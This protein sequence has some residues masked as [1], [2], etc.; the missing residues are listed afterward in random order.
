MSIKGKAESYVKMRGSISKPDAIVG[1]SAYEI[2]LAHGFEGTE[3]E[4][5][6]SLKGEDGEQGKPFEYEDFTE[7]QLAALKGE[8]GDPHVSITNVQQSTASGGISV[9]EFSDGHTLSIFNGTNG[10]RGM[11]GQRG[12]GI[13][14]MTVSPT[15]YAGTAIA[16]KMPVGRYVLS[17]LKFYS[18]DYEVFVGDY[19]L[20]NYNL[21]H[22]Y[23]IDSTYA[24]LD[25]NV[26]L[27][28]ANGTT[29]VKGTDYWTAADKAAIVSDVLAA[30]PTWEGGSY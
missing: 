20:C 6:L 9:I 19:V 25:T 23:H 13:I 4:W 17:T 16:G 30:L 24:Y 15:S 27:K 28:G 26:Y 12:T 5:L 3:E 29:P 18:S 22:I 8:K 2:A 1:K 11:T 14:T 10:A 7:E 21:Y